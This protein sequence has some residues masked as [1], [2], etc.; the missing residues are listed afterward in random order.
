L[1]GPGLLQAMRRLALPLA[2]LLVAASTPLAASASSSCTG[3]EDAWFLG[4]VYD[5]A[6]RADFKQDFE[7]F[8]YFLGELDDVYCIP[9]AQSEILAFDGAW[10]HAGNT[11]SGYT[12]ATEANV[13]SHLQDFGA[14]ASADDDA[15]FFLF[16]SSHGLMYTQ[17]LSTCPLA[18]A[19][20]SYA[21]LGTG[22]S[23]DGL[24]HDCELGSL[25]GSEFDASI[26]KFVAV[27][28]SFCGGFSDS[29]TAA[30]GTVPDGAV[31][32]SAGVVGNNRI[33]VTGCAITTEC[34]GGGSLGG[35][36]LYDAMRQVLSGGPAACDGWTAPG[37][38]LV[39]GVGAPMKNTLVRPQDGTCTASE[40]FFASVWTSWQTGSV[41]SMALSIQEQQRIKYRMPSLA[42]DI[43]IQ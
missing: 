30:S 2:A 42:D 11:Y 18:R 24:L 38:P 22:G 23:E 28:C 12:P 37:F 35:A 19:Y 5:A 8:Q 41:Q 10:S 15:T 16:L 27:D 34:F 32:Q 33:V 29:L 9:A 43:V 4:I 17:P 3:K 31:R 14:D 25:L 20:G 21:A 40:W 36:L 13:K 7:N 39:Q 6:E 26:P 1:N